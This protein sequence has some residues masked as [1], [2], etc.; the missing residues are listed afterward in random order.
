M[1]RPV[2]QL[3]FITL[4]SSSLLTA[5]VRADG[6][7]LGP[8]GAAAVAR[9][10]ANAARP[11]DL[12]TMLQN[13]AGLVDLHGAQGY[14][15]LDTAFN[16]IC[17]HPYG[18]YGWGVYETDLDDPDV[19]RSEFGDPTSSAYSKQHLDTVCNS[20]PIVPLPQLAFGF[21]LGERVTVAL[22]FVAPLFV[23]GARFGGKDG[24]ITGADGKAWP[25]P[26]RYALITT[27]AAGF[28]P[29]GSIGVKVTPWLALG[30]TVQATMA[31]VSSYQVLAL[32]AGTSPVNDIYSRLNGSDLFVPWLTLSAYVKPTRRI[33]V[34][35]SFTWSDGFDGH[36]EM[37]FTTGYYH[38]GASGNELIPYDNDP[39]KLKRIKVGLPWNASL[40]VRYAQPS[41]DST[42]VDD[43]MKS[44]IWDVEIDGTFIANKSAGSNKV[45]I[46][47]DFLLEF[48]RAN[49]EPQMPLDV[50][51]EDLK[52]LNVER[53]LLNSVALRVGGSYN[54]IPGRLALSLGGFF[55][56]RTTSASY[57]SVANYGFG[58]IGIGL[59]AVV[60]LGKVELA[61]AY[62]HVFQEII[63][64]A[65]PPHQPRTEATD[66]KQSGFDQR[67]YEN[68]QLSDKPK[69]DPAA[70]SPSAASGVA[71]GQQTA[72]FETDNLRARVVNAGRYVTSFDVLSL[73]VA[74]H[75]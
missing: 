72:V 56:S 23:G 58:R 14:Y 45:E 57:A 70:P 11:T 4:L 47:N 28:N 62:S 33:R 9:G 30:A 38:S 36:G 68:G 15:S 34:A 19:H 41:S 31:S 66:D 10:G 73:S 32:R 12:S 40:A 39:I 43:V 25:T 26:T 1:S 67:V 71:S 24:T 42:D 61:A 55:Q 75:F 50:K 48:R 44:E 18:Y 13:P 63:D 52:A 7:Q 22:G 51:Q 59:G 29:T 35:G 64:L 37:F 20:S 8:S 60:R 16:S 49:S 65:P 69:T 5:S 2:R 6:E 17:F 53:N 21:N 74:H 54:I 27:E 3:T 46:E